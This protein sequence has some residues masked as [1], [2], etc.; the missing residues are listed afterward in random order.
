LFLCVNTKDLFKLN[1]V[2]CLGRKYIAK[3]ICFGSWL[4]L[5]RIPYLEHPDKFSEC[6]AGSITLPWTNDLY[7]EEIKYHGYRCKNKVCAYP[8]CSSNSRFW[9][10]C[11]NPPVL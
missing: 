6:S 1:P 9:L 10:P 2:Y 3:Y 11:C 5:I 7:F 4:E 8:L